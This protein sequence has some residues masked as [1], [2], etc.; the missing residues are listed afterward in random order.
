VA[1]PLDLHVRL[2]APIPR[3]VCTGA[4]SVVFVAGWCWCERGAVSSLEF[5]LDGARQPVMAHGMPRLDPLRET[6][7]PLA[8]R[9]GFWGMVRLAPPAHDGEAVLALVARL[10]GGSEA[11][12]EVGRIVLQREL[13]PVAGMARAGGETGSRLAAGAAAGPGSTGASAPRVAI[14]MATY[15]PPVDLLRRQLDSIRAQTHE[16][17]VCYVSDDCSGPRGAAAL[18][19]AI[20]DDPRFV[21][22]RSPRRL[23]F[24]HNFERALAMVAAGGEAIDFVALSDQDDAWY[25]EKLTRLLGAIGDAQLVYSDARIVSRDGTRVADSYWGTRRN[26]HWDL[27]SLMVA[28]SV[29]GAASLFRR[30]LLDIALPFPPGQFA[31]YHDHWIALVAASVGEINFLDAPLY[32][33][34]QHSQ[35]SLGHEKAN[36]MPSLGHRVRG[37]W[38]RGLRERIRKWRM[39]YF[40]DIARLLQVC[41]VLD[42]RCGER[43]RGPARRVIRRFEEVERSPALAAQ[44]LV[45]GTREL[46]GRPETLGAEW[47]LLFG[48]LWRR[49]VELSARPAPQGR[50]RVD[51]LPPPDLAPGVA[52]GSSGF[53]LPG[54]TR[55]VLEKI[56]PLALTVSA[57]APARVN[58]LIPTI[59]LDH[60]FGGYIGKFNLARALARRG[61]RV[62]VV[63]VDRTP[64][65]PSGW[66]RRIEAFAGLDGVFDS[67]EVAFGREGDLEVSPADAW[68]ATTWW[69]AHLAR[70]AG[71]VGSGRFLYLIQE[72]EPFTFPMGTLAALAEQSYT[73]EHAALFSTQ[74]LRDFFRARRIG[75]FAAGPRRGERLSAAFRN[76]IT[77]VPPPSFEELAARTGRSLLFYARPEPHAERNL[78]DLGLLALGEAGSTGALGADWTLRGVGSVE[79]TSRVDLG[80]GMVLELLP[81]SAQADYAALLRDHDVGLAL[82]YT[83]HPSLVPLEMASAGLLTVTNSF[84]NKT[85]EAMTALSANLI[86]AEPNVEELAAALGR[87]AAA[88]PDFERRAAG[89]RFDWPRSWEESFNDEVLSFVE[90]ALG[91]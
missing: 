48:I 54:S 75:V 18:A 13:P 64:P 41:L 82:M 79:R 25:P 26:N 1:A 71:P 30:G 45:R 39:H 11:R 83:P 4:G 16:N 5:E 7:E 49:M 38:T 56:T 17:W 33:Y 90:A 12:A 77:P 37:L 76:A 27:L 47:M 80:H 42:M 85:A 19:A 88:V 51:A 50:T 72:Y 6:G 60:F 34:V 68:I 58:L 8:Y 3:V 28:N 31:H 20:G 70:A 36:R 32:D 73:F 74:L 52:R 84:A 43:M 2:D 35:A 63:T 9:S 21:V 78:Y 86:V 81:R 14:C 65:L 57:D 91:L 15:E 59:D 40:V 44:L 23:G 29:T 62:R 55:T 67:V 87:A 10:E 61:H 89:A 46:F 24:Y 53:S 69:T 22:S 66:R